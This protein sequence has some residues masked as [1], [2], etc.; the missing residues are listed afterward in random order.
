MPWRIYNKRTKQMQTFEHNGEIFTYEIKHDSDQGAPWEDKDGHGP[1]SE[2]TKRDKLPGELILSEG[3]MGNLY[4]DY[5]GACKQA[6]VEGWNAAPYDIPG[7]TKHQQAC[8]AAL[9]DYNWLRRW[10]NDLGVS[11]VGIVV[12][13]AGAC[14]C[15]GDYE[16]LW[17]IW[18]DI[19]SE[20]SWEYLEQTAHELAGDLAK[21]AD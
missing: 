14:E 18:H 4:Y 9:A 15:C 1:V 2:W 19:D 20:K 12:R 7:E 6:F 11:P 3:R 17:G 13:R 10:A 5:A 16:S 8:R 21:W